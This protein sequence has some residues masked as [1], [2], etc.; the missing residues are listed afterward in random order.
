MNTKLQI[1]ALLT[2]LLLSAGVGCESDDESS[3]EQSEESDMPEQADESDEA[4]EA[5]EDGQADEPEEEEIAGPVSE[6]ALM[7]LFPESVD[8]WTRTADVGSSVDPDAEE[9]SARNMMVHA[10]YET[11]GDDEPRP[12]EVVIQCHQQRA[13]FV[14]EL[15]ENPVGHVEESENVEGLRTE[16]VEV[17][18]LRAM[19]RRSTVTG[20]GRQSEVHVRLD[21]ECSIAI[22]TYGTEEPQE[23]AIDLAEKLP[24][25][26]FDEARVA[27]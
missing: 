19:E 25:G 14:A 26:D 12:A 4:V 24:L 17:A 20:R 11:T 22:T 15:A 9:R 6:E 21:A 23:L 16:W 10:N 18:D 3:T 7:A 27:E 13:D 2:I 8:G 5:D 1:I